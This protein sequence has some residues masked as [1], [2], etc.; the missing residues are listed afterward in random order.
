[1]LDVDM[2]NEATFGGLFRPARPD[3]QHRGQSGSAHGALGADHRV[4]QS[5]RC[6]GGHRQG[7]QLHAGRD[8]PTG[9]TRVKLTVAQRLGQ[10]PR[11]QRGDVFGHGPA[12]SG[13]NNNLTSSEYRLLDGP[14][15]LPRRQ[16]SRVIT[17]LKTASWQDTT[18]RNIW[19]ARGDWD[20]VVSIKGVQFLPFHFNGEGNLPV[21]DLPAC[22][23]KA[24]PRPG[25]PSARGF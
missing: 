13:W 20:S 24:K 1:M 9:Q 16:F 21:R 14:P 17:N 12:A 3:S 6:A 7:W 5:G 11:K 19:Y 15:L 18:D 8:V 10:H 25:N 2:H 23:L 4:G 22:D